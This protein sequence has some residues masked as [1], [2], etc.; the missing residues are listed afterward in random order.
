M[1]PT[2]ALSPKASLE[3]QSLLL[4]VE[5]RDINNEAAVPDCAPPLVLPLQVLMFYIYFLSNHHRIFLLLDT[6]ET[7]VW[8]VRW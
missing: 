6:E 3:I 8:C 2:P 4:L 1:Q 7:V 5:G